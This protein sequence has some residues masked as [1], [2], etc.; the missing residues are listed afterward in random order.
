VNNRFKRYILTWVACGGCFLPLL[1][2]G[3][4]ATSVQAKSLAVVDR[5]LQYCSSV[6]PGVASK[7]RQK[8]KDLT[9]GLTDQQVA[10]LRQTEEYQ[11]AYAS[12]EEFV[13]KVDEHNAK[14]V[15]SESLSQN[16]N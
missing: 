3:D 2:Y 15:C 6:D 12:I 1:A 10:D 13:G 8:I 5:V 7:L 11:A 14:K 4:Q 9:K 16:N